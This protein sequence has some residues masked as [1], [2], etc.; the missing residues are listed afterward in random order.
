MSNLE[1][2][3]H[4]SIEDIEL[5]IAK[6]S[7]SNSGEYDTTIEIL[8][9]YLKTHKASLAFIK[10]KNTEKNPLNL[11]ANWGCSDRLCDI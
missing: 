6:L 10:A 1:S 3:V 5:E 2:T 4:K 8:N 7:A 11:P 9:S